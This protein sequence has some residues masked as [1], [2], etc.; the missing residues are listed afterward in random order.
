MDPTKFAINH[1]KNIAS[2]MLQ[3]WLYNDQFKSLTS[4][5]FSIWNDH[6]NRF[7]NNPRF[8]K[9]FFKTIEMGYDNRAYHKILDTFLRESDVER[10]ADRMQVVT[11]LVYDPNVLLWR[12]L[13]SP[14]VYVR[15]HQPDR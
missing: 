11:P 7:K 10:F 15:S 1:A 14:I 5:L 4:T 6:I 3:Y 12:P 9:S 2:M 8:V 13:G